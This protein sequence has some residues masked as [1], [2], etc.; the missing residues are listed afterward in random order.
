MPATQPSIEELLVQYFGWDS[1]PTVD[2]SGWN[3]AYETYIT[4][5]QAQALFNYGRSNGAR[6]GSSIISY[7]GEGWDWSS[8]NPQYA[9]SLLGQNGQLFKLTGGQGF[10]LNPVEAPYASMDSSGNF[11]NN[12]GS[13]WGYKLTYAKGADG[14]NTA[15]GQMASHQDFMDRIAPYLPLLL[16]GGAMAVGGTGAGA[17]GSAAGYG[18]GATVY[19][20]GVAPAVDGM[21]AF[22]AG[23]TLGAGGAAAGLGQGALTAEQQIALQQAAQNPSFMQQL[24]QSPIGTAAKALGLTNSDG[25]LNIGSMIK[26]GLLTAGALG[27]GGAISNLTG[28][29]GV[30]GVSNDFVGAAKE[31]AAGNWQNLLGSSKLNHPNLNG[32]QGSVTWEYDPVTGQWTSKTALSAGE[33]NLYDQ[34]VQSGLLRGD[35]VNQAL[36]N[37]ANTLTKG[38]DLSALPS[39]PINPGTTAYDAIMSRLEP[40]LTREQQSLDTALANSG[41]DPGSAGYAAKQQL[42]G[43]NRNDL[44]LNAA[45]EAI[46]LDTTARQNALNEQVTMQ[47]TPLKNIATLMSLPSTSYT[48]PNFGTTWTPASTTPGADILGATQ[49]AGAQQTANNSLATATKNANLNGLVGIGS[50]LLSSDGF[51]NWLK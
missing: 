26:A 18:P 32:P 28:G 44:R 8:G 43:Q 36:Y 1:L 13:P 51:W 6:V 29:T 7:G 25:S 45:K 21:A 20:P 22:N 16:A 5:D 12:S 48:Q 3:G 19:A 31:T 15:Q 33:Q 30:G 17:A 41:F 42:F 34:S 39:A 37:N 49:M 4:P 2:G 11:I 38:I 24:V 47:Q 40:Q 9:D 46:G 27:A 14:W 23:N 50:S 35:L 10:S